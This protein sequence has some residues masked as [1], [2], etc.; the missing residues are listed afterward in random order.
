MRLGPPTAGPRL[1]D[2]APGAHTLGWRAFL[3]GL[4]LVLS[5]PGFAG[6]ATSKSDRYPIGI[7]AVPDPGDLPGLRAAGFSVVIGEATSPYLDAADAA[8]IRVLAPPG[9][10]VGPKRFDAERATGTVRQFDRHP[11]LWGW[12]LCDEPDLYR[13]APSELAR[14]RAS[15]H[16]AGARRPVV[17]SLYYSREADLYA[18][19]ADQLILDRY[20]I[21]WLPLADFPKHLRLARFAA[22]P[23]RPL[24]A[25]IQAFDWGHF[26]ELVRSESGFRPPTPA[27]IRAMTYLT[28]AE[29]ARGLFFY[30]F[31]QPRWRIREHPAIWDAVRGIVSEV[32]DRENLFE[33]EV[34]WSDFEVSYPVPGT[35]RNEALEPAIETA[36]IHVRRAGTSIPA[37]DL[38][39]AVNTTPQPLR[40]R[41]RWPGGPESPLPVIDEARSLVAQDGWFEDA[42]DGF[43]VHLYGPVPRRSPRVGRSTG[44]PRPPFSEN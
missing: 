29:G 4:V 6:C 1:P 21:P 11:A 16:R 39:L 32:R 40:W 25:A 5:G 34:R 23:R 22:G 44:P 18:C 35:G 14:A 43:A 17:V 41:L 27:E 7:F 31:D 13:I 2:S 36:R 28:L 8:G 26:P 37:G 19:E 30:C 24:F 15:L 12:Y 10:A 38:V 42:F 20:P 3:A 9:T 33:G